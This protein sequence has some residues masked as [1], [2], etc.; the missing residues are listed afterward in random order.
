[1]PPVPTTP[2]WRK[3]SHSGHDGGNCVEVA[4]LEDRIAVRDSKKPSAPAIMISPGDW[5][6]LING[7][8]TA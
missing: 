1:M 8:K 2:R 3:S 5:R 6:K 7:L 4:A